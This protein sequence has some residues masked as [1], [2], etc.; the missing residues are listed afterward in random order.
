MGAAEHSFKEPKHRLSLKEVPETSSVLL[1]G[2]G[3][4][5]EEWGRKLGWSAVAWGS[6]ILN[7]SQEIS[8]WS[9]CDG[10]L[11]FSWV[12]PGT[13]EAHLLNS[14]GGRERERRKGKRELPS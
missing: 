13:C 11:P 2:K 7:S 10:A 12:F 6:P 14:G 3:I 5:A 8:C 9:R 1:G 4:R